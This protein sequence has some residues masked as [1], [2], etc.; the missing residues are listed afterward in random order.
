[1][2]ATPTKA[3]RERMDTIARMGCILSFYKSG[4]WGTPGVVHHML[5]GRVPSRRASHM[6]T[7]CLAPRYHQYSPEAI[8]DL[9]L[10]RFAALHGITE[11]GLFD[12]T[13]EMMTVAA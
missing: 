5:T 11:E 1:V 7:I 2:T 9:G 3:E 10:D 13:N 4:L 6:R 8:H 12:L